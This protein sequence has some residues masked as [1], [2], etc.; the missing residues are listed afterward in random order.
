MFTQHLLSS[1]KPEY[2]EAAREAGIQGTV[3]FKVVLGTEGKLISAERSAGPPELTEVVRKTI[4][5][6]VWE[7]IRVGGEPVEVS[8]TVDVNFSLAK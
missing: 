2:P 1:P 3:H 4:M 6:W 8:S 5:Q 7:K